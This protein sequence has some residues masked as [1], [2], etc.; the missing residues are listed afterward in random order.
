[1]LLALYGLGSKAVNRLWRDQKGIGTLEL[2]LI[3][4]V[5]IILILIFKDWIVTFINKMLG[6][7]DNESKKLFSNN[8]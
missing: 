5:I 8:S 3:V 2:V 6:N 1:M 4:A 7:V